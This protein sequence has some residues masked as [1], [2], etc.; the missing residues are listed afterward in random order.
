MQKN[1]LSSLEKIVL[2]IVFVLM[3]IGIIA[4]WVNKTWFLE[5]YVVEDGFIEDVTLIPLAIL[6]LTCVILLFKYARKKKRMV[7]FHL[8]LYCVRQFFY[9]G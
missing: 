7:F 1:K 2:S 9:F 5:T 8:P 6:T 4:A 3:V